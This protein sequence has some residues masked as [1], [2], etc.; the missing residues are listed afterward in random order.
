MKL[1]LQTDQKILRAYIEQRIRNYGKEVNDGP[2]DAQSPISLVT[3]GYYAEQGGYVNLVFDTRQDAETDG[4]WTL[5][6]ENEKNTQ[7]FPEWLSACRAIYN[8]EVVSVTRH[9]GTT[10]DLQESDGDEKIQ[11]VFGDMIVDLMKQLRDDGTLL[12]LPLAPQAHMV[13]EEFDGRYFWPSNQQPHEGLL[14]P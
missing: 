11:G 14:A 8:G 3:F 7:N 13:L 1:N 6:I 2:G 5:H 10:C 12:K 4:H 9:D